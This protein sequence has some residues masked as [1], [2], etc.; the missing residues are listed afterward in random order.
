MLKSGP[1]RRHIL[2]S[3]CFVT[4][5]LL[6]LPAIARPPQDPH[7]ALYRLDLG[8]VTGAPSVIGAKGLMTAEWERGCD[9]WTATQ[10]LALTMEKQEGETTSSTVSASVFE[11]H[12]GRK[13]RFTSKTTVDGEVVEQV[14]GRAERPSATAPG[15]AYYI[16]PKG[17][18]IDLPAGT[19]FPFQH[20]LAI[21]DAA[22]SGADRDFSPFFDG[23]QPEDSP[24][25]VNSL[26][27][28]PARPASE[29]PGAG[30]GPLTNHVWWPV[31]LAFFAHN[32]KSDEPDIEMTQYVQENG[33]IRQFDFDYGDFTIVAKLERVEPVKAP[34]C[35]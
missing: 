23:S 9:G 32:D 15:K 26:V 30:L 29:G 31:R 18:T 33:V 3:L 35:N 34:R 12:D 14:R 7:R 25:W 22:A 1:A 2:A 11:T 21:L 24:L 28:G 8:R 4:A 10:K 13:L 17:L 6:A 20:T 27:L 16:E 19:L 5:I